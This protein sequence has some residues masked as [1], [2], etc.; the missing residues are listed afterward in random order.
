MMPGVCSGCLNQR[1]RQSS[2][3]AS[4]QCE[5]QLFRM[6]QLPACNSSPAPRPATDGWD[7]SC[8]NVSCATG[9]SDICECGCQ[10]SRVLWTVVFICVAWKPH[11]GIRSA[12]DRHKPKA[13]HS[14]RRGCLPLL[15][16][17][18]LSGK[19][20]LLPVTKMHQ[21][22][23][24]EWVHCLKS[25]STKIWGVTQSRSSK[26]SEKLKPCTELNSELRSPIPKASEQTL[27]KKEEVQ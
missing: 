6:H 20:L 9:D 14:P 23:K 10:P 7:L 1:H 5:T 27:H 12:C 2:A 13:L 22:W 17:S 4:Q 18:C 21:K 11:L 8:D 26:H 3:C 25:H 19:A 16:F 15:L 24:Q